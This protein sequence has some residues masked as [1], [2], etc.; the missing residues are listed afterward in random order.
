MHTYSS[1]PLKKRAFKEKVNSRCFC[2]FP[3]AILVHQNG[4]PIWRLHTKLYKGAWNVLTNNSETVDHKD[5]RLGQ[6][7]CKLVFYDIFS[8]SW[9]LSLDKRS[10]NKP[11][12]LLA[13]LCWKLKGRG[14]GA[15]DEWD[16][17]THGKVHLKKCIAFFVLCFTKDD[18]EDF[19]EEQSLMGKLV[20]LLKSDNPDQQYLVSCSFESPSNWLALTG[21]L[22]IRQNLE[23]H[24][25]LK[26]SLVN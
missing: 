6:I 22:W 20:T 25:K 8:F 11:L 2:W 5:L 7:V 15:W 16:Y 9:L 24:G 4:V 10:I 12:T 14:K 21:F 26:L 3:V 18:P 1:S 23:S 19:V 13:L 17:N